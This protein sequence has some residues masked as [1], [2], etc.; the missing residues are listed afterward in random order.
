MKVDERLR[1]IISTVSVLLLHLSSN[2]FYARSSF[3]SYQE[4]AFRR[5]ALS[6]NMRLNHIAVDSSDETPP[7]AKRPLTIGQLFKRPRFDDVTC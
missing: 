3:E 2:E 5:L 4:P 7:T 6:Y 1:F